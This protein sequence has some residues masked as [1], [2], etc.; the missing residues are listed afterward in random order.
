MFSGL[1]KA[2]AQGF[3]E[4]SKRQGKTDKCLAEM[5]SEIAVLSDLCQRQSAAIESL[6]QEVDAMRKLLTPGESIR[7]NSEKAMLRSGYFDLNRGTVFPSISRELTPRCAFAVKPDE[8]DPRAVEFSL[9]N[10]Q[11]I[12]SYDGIEDAVEFA[13]EECT[14]AEAAR[15]TTEEP[16]KARIGDDGLWHILKRTKIRLS[17]GL[18]A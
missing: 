7:Q 14:L 4:I 17:K 16:G 18:N 10:L 8:N 1:K 9:Q 12:R 15:F 3:A 11:R 6:R 2:I 13:G 5:S